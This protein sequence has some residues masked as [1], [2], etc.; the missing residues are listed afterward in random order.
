MS[1]RLRIGFVGSCP[2][3]DRG[4]GRLVAAGSELADGSNFAV[5]VFQEILNFVTA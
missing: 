4:G 2:M 5:A 1:E 3:D